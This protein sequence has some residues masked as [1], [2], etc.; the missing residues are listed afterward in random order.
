M[1][2]SRPT[3]PL[4]PLLA[5]CALFLALLTGCASSQHG[6]VWKHDTWRDTLLIGDRH[7]RVTDATELYAADG[8]RIRLD[9]VPTVADPGVGVRHLERA[10]VEFLATDRGRERELHTLWVVPAR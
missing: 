1:S 6:T 5:S 10:R 7:Y 9:Q 8:R 4:I 2:P 3:P